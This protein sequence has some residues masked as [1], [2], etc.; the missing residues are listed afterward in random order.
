MSNP[1]SNTASAL[2]TQ[3]GAFASGSGSI[4]ISPGFVRAQNDTFGNAA[5]SASAGQSSGAYDTTAWLGNNNTSGGAALVSLLYPAVVHLTGSA[6]FNSDSG[7]GSTSVDLSDAT[8]S[9]FGLTLTPSG[10]TNRLTSPIDQTLSLPAGN[11]YLTAAANAQG[12]ALAGFASGNLS[13]ALSSAG[14]DITVTILS[15]GLLGDANFD[16]TVN[17]LDFSALASHFGTSSG[18]T[19]ADG[20]FNGDGIVNAVDFNDIAMNFG[21]TAGAPTALGSALTPEP[22][23]G[24]VLLAMACNL[25]FPRITRN[26]AARRSAAPR[27]S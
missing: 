23:S 9:L 5:A 14:Y 25:P 4:S 18:A 6:F 10:D 8:H 13:P 3:A 15:S 2:I 11:Y 20:D 22:A 26:V 24:L 27:R 19:W 7:S 17:A 21:Q 1:M 16:D 12:S